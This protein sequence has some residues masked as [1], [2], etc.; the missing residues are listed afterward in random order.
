MATETFR[1]RRHDASAEML[2]KAAETAMIRTGFDAV[3]MRDVAAEAG[4]SPGTLYQYFT[5]KQ[6]LL[7]AIFERHSTTLIA[8]IRA[9]HASIG[10]PLE[11]LKLGTQCVLEYLGQNRAVF[12]LFYMTAPRTPGDPIARMPAGPRAGWEKLCRDETE[13]I[14]K[15]QRQGRVRKDLSAEVLH[16][17]MRRLESGM[18][19]EFVAEDAPRKQT[20]HLRIIWSFL[21]HG[22][23]ATEK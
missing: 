19:E 8:L 11:K 21:L 13:L 5:N 14:A 1:Q 15:A 6:E 10:D 3:T 20:E 22:F 17:C 12:V 7:D 9:A 2:L 23:G 18:I 16:R 4:C